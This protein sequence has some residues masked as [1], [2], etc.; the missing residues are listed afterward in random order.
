VRNIAFDGSVG[1]LLWIEKPFKTLGDFRNTLAEIWHTQRYPHSLKNAMDQV[2]VLKNR[3]ATLEYENKKLSELLHIPQM[4]EQ[5]MLT[6][7]CIGSKIHP[8]RQVIFIH[9][10]LKQGVKTRQPVF[11]KNQLIGQ[12]DHVTENNGRILL[13][14]DEKSRIPVCFA[15]SKA[16]GI[17]TGDGNGNLIIP[18]RNS[19]EAITPG[20]KVFT[21]GHGGTFPAHKLIGE[22]MIVKGDI[23]YVKPAISFQKLTYVQI[24]LNH[25]WEEVAELPDEDN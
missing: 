7:P 20:D 17:L 6:V 16:E 21:S 23:L 2:Q 18:Y 1:L 8:Y 9:A 14:T 13:I 3:N 5:G 24:M 15:Q 12:V 11:F 22:I 4:T 25:T 10:G 19:V